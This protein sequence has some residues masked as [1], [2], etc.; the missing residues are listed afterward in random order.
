MRFAAYFHKTRFVTVLR[1]FALFCGALCR[2]SVK[3]VL[4]NT[5]NFFCSWKTPAIHERI[6]SFSCFPVFF[7]VFRVFCVFCWN[8]AKHSQNTA[9]HPQD[10]TKHPQNTTKHHKTHLLT[11]QPEFADKPALAPRCNHYHLH[12]FV[13]PLILI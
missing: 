5:V 4:C 1:C 8:T 6:V 7:D 11:K 2:C 10:I 13:V 12:G 3:G 9:K